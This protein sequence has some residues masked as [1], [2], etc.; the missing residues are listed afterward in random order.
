MRKVASRCV[1]LHHRPSTILRGMWCKSITIC[2]RI[3][4]RAAM[5]TAAESNPVLMMSDTQD[6][7]DQRRENHSPKEHV[8]PFPTALRMMCLSHRLPFAAIH[9]WGLE[10]RPGMLAHPR[11]GRFRVRWSC[12][13]PP[14]IRETIVAPSTT[15]VVF[16]FRAIFRR[17]TAFPSSG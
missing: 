15:L 17:S 13:T 6:E 4:V 7:P 14:E 1:S 2:K 5:E 16:H 11:P 9:N 12:E 10:S 3:H 8:L